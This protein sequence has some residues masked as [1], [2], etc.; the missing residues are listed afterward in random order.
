MGEAR[1]NPRRSRPGPRSASP[2]GRPPPKAWS[3]IV[4]VGIEGSSI[5]KQPPC[6]LGQYGWGG[7]GVGKV[8]RMCVQCP[9]WQKPF[10]A[11][12]CRGHLAEVTVKTCPRKSL[13]SN[14][15]AHQSQHS[16]HKHKP[17]D[18]AAEQDNA[19]LI[20]LAQHTPA[21]TR[22]STCNRHSYQQ[23][24]TTRLL[25]GTHT[26]AANHKPQ[27]LPPPKPTPRFSAAAPVNL[28]TPS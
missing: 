6:N 4:S 15:Y 3:H 10:I 7:V 24:P 17:A 19:F 18:C 9:A 28:E 16:H 12:A 13:S 27:L 21:T 25:Q 22:A 5:L 23:T 2:C 14:V 1:S 11:A 20:P 8:D 26:T